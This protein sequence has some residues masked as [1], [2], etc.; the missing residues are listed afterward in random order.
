MTDGSAARSPWVA[1]LYDLATA[2]VSI[3]DAV[4]N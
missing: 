2:I 1:A 4:T 3:Q